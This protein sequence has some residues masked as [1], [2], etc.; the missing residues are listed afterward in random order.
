MMRFIWR[1][2]LG[3]LKLRIRQIIEDV[4]ELVITEDVLELVLILV[5]SVRSVLPIIM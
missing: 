5:R 3:H 1:G 2:S 4:L